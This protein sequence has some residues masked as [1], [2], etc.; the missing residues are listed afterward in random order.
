VANQK[1]MEAGARTSSSDRWSTWVESFGWT[2]L[3]SKK[4]DLGSHGGYRQILGDNL[5]NW[6]TDE[7]RWRES[8]FT[9]AW[10]TAGGPEAC[11]F[12]IRSIE[13]WPDEYLLTDLGEECKR[14]LTPPPPPPRDGRADLLAWWILLDR[15]QKPLWQFR[16]KDRVSRLCDQVYETVMVTRVGNAI[17]RGLK[18][19][20]FTISQDNC[21]QVVKEAYREIFDLSFEHTLEH[22]YRDGWQILKVASKYRARKGEAW[23]YLHRSIENWISDFLRRQDG[24]FRVPTIHIADRFRAILARAHGQI[25]VNRLK[26]PGDGDE[27]DLLSTL[28]YTEGED[29]TGPCETDYALT[30]KLD[31]CVE[32][33]MASSSPVEKAVF[34][35]SYVPP[36]SLSRN[37]VSKLADEVGV[38]SGS[39]IDFVIMRDNRLEL[40]GLLAEVCEVKGK[41]LAS[42]LDKT[43]N[44]LKGTL[45][46]QGLPLQEAQ[47]QIDRWEMEALSGNLKKGELRDVRR[48]S[49]AESREYLAA[50][51]QELVIQLKDVRGK[52]QESSEESNRSHEFS[53]EERKILAEMLDTTS[54]RIQQHEAAV[55][56]RIIQCMEA[57]CG[58]SE[59]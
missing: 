38:P 51:L 59:Q 35:L 8:G 45:T 23:Q 25:E 53:K 19:K 5:C 16:R 36:Q 50:H 32:R 1:P 28:H 30:S 13:A 54:R 27:S 41:Y 47:W 52:M 7:K 42:L 21:P 24:K 20:G 31:E 17:F 43:R 15:G 12:I 14:G 39:L 40:A 3:K 10:G 55:R 57:P 37:A 58:G 33:V 22:F 9:K 56:K 18:K 46:H 2:Y 26:G 4:D 6:L 48:N 11:E 34:L 44:T 49:P 29:D